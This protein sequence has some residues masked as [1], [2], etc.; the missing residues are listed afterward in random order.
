MTVTSLY[1]PILNISLSPPLRSMMMGVFPGPT[2][3]LS[4]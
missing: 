4:L 3:L 2:I 1:F